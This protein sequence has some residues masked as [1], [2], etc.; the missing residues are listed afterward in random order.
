MCVYV[1]WGGM[2]GMGCARATRAF[3]AYVMM[4]D[5]MGDEEEVW[6]VRGEWVLVEVL[7]VICVVGWLGEVVV[8]VRRCVRARRRATR[9]TV[10]VGCDEGDEVYGV[11]V[12]V[13]M[14]VC[15]RILSDVVVEFGEML[16]GNCLGVGWNEEGDED[17]EEDWG[18]W[19]DE[20]EVRDEVLVED[21]REGMG[22]GW[23]DVLMLML[24]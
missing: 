9:A 4:D 6:D 16:M 15:E 8:N 18:S 2:S 1:G 7:L 20:D 12:E 5:V 19:G 22:D 10:F 24:K 17:D 11:C 21:L 13:L 23:N 3:E 14:E